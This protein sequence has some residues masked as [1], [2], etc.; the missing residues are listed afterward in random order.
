MTT[1]T[2]QHASAGSIPML[3]REM[4][5]P[6][7]WR[8]DNIGPSDW[9]VPVSAEATREM[10]AAVRRMRE[11]P[12][13]TPS[14]TPGM[15]DLQHC[16]GIA[17]RI[18]QLLDHGPGFVV[19]DR[20]PMDEISFEE[21][22]ALSWLMASLIARPVIQNIHGV[23]LY[24][25]KDSG[26]GHG[27]GVRGDSTN[28]NLNFHTDNCYNEALPEYLGLLCLSKGLEGGLS[29]A[30]SFYSV[31]NELRRRAP[32]SR[33]P[34]ARRERQQHARPGPVHRQCRRRRIGDRPCRHPE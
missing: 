3:D 11:Q 12:A 29:K 16:S 17:E 24:D 32:P 26:K 6:C 21:G 13:E 23:Q 2:Q 19:M 18:K 15:F 20:L 1:S 31:H 22:K 30:I 25:V 14:L 10:V 5:G 8:R 34:D 28:V 33:R 27:N 9:T 4:T 7:A